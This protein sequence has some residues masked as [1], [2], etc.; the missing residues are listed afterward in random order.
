V[1]AAPSAPATTAKPPEGAPRGVD[2][3]LHQAAEL[4]QKKEYPKAVDTLEEAIRVHPEAANL[5][6]QLALAYWYKALQKPDGS[7]RSTME[8]ASYHKAIK[9]FQTFLEKAPNDPLANEARMRLTV[10]R[11][12][13]YGGG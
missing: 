7:R 6:F 8:K 5:H 4:M 3:F 12:A 2:T 13:Q 11:N 1:A 10:L 9:S